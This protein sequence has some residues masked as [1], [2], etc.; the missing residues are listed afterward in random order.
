[1]G[2]GQTGPEISSP[3]H[4]LGHF[5]S[6]G[7]TIKNIL[8][9]IDFTCPNMHFVRLS[10]NYDKQGQRYPLRPTFGV[11]FGTMVGRSKIYFAKSILHALI[12]ILFDFY[13]ARSN[14]T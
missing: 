4:L 12:Y 9:Q 6:Y 11:T 3:A 8:C 5:W 13:R 2:L 1:M 7:G 14:S 10:W